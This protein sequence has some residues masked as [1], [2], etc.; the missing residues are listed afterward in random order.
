MLAPL[1]HAEG[2]RKC[3]LIGVS[4]KSSA[5]G[6][7]DAIDPQADMPTSGVMSTS[8]L[9]RSLRHLPSSTDSSCGQPRRRDSQNV[10]RK[11]SQIGGKTRRK[12]SFA[13]VLALRIGA[14]GSIG[15]QRLFA[16]QCFG[17]IAGDQDSQHQIEK[18]ILFGYAAVGTERQRNAGVNKTLKHDLMIELGPAIAAGCTGRP[19]PAA[20]RSSS[21]GEKPDGSE[22]SGQQGERGA[23]PHDQRHLPRLLISV[24]PSGAMKS[25]EMQK[26]GR[27]WP[28]P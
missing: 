26:L 28:A 22:R 27:R 13:L 25:G 1:R 21:L 15:R 16:R 6:K 12:P 24:P 20:R 8:H 19:P 18:R 9:R 11:H 23:R 2:L 10:L 4:R 3:L 17:G 14:T 7:N 5:H